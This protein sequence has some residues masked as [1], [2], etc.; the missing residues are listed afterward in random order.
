MLLPHGVSFRSSSTP[1]VTMGNIIMVDPLHIKAKGRM[2]FTM[3]FN[4]SPTAP[5]RLVFRSFLNDPLMYCEA[6]DGLTVCMSII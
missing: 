3:S 6:T 5:S 4:I 1:A 2:M